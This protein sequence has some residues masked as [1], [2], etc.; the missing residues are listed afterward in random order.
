MLVDAN[1]L[2]YARDRSS[3]FHEAARAWLEDVLNGPSRVGLPW[4]SLAAFLRISTH[5]R[6]TRE[7]LAPGV[8]WA[9]IESWLAAPAA[10]TPTPTDRHAEVLGELVDAHQLAGNL[11]PDAHL[12]TLAICH[13]I[14]VCSA[15]SDFARFDQVH[16]V[17]PV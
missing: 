13:G 14:A 8:A 2:L 1:L 10:W 15:D 7:P 11:I 16:W 17:N 3:R 4:E 12:A 5:P 9:Q 6:A